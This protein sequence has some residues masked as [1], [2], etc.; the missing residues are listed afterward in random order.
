MTTERLYYRDPYL[1]KF[2]AR[3][4]ERGE[5][6]GLPAVVLDRSA[7]YPTGGGQ[8]HD[9]GHL[10][11]AAVVE[12]VE[13]EEDKAVVHLLEKQVEQDEVSGEIDWP[14]RF[15]LM[16]QHSGQHI[17]S[18]AFDMVLK[19]ETVSVHF[20]EDCATVDLDRALTPQEME[21]VERE[22]N[23]V[24]WENRPVT[25]RFVGEV[26]LASMPLRKQP[27]VSGPVRIVEVS[28]L[29]WSPCGGTHVAHS[30][31]IGLIKLL[32]AERRG[33]ETRVEFLCGGRALADYRAKNRAVLELAAHLSVGHGQLAEAVSRLEEECKALRKERDALR[34]ELIPIEAA[35]M[36]NAAEERGGVRVVRKAFLGREARSLRLLASCLAGQGRCLALLGSTGEKASLVFA[37]SEDLTLDVRPLLSAA[38]AVVGGKGGGQPGFAQGG[39]PQVERLEE[40][41]EAAYRAWSGAG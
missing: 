37:R 2:T 15:D 11:G 34:D 8:P 19:A 1:R 20:G 12:V 6:N 41:L 7:F 39:G 29:D 31:E 10:N 28:G 27:S 38:C 40:A 3:V 16:Q 21:M 17:L 4:V 22:A 23:A 33:A 32:R 13:R 26:E 25:A 9:T 18:A 5:L 35:A 30:A 14:R 36:L 24:V